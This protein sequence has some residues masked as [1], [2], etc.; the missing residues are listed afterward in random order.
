VGALMGEFYDVVARWKA[1]PAVW[2]DQ[3]QKGWRTY[4]AYLVQYIRREKL[5]GQVL[6]KNTGI[7]DAAG[8]GGRGQ[9]RWRHKPG[10]LKKTFGAQV[11]N[12]LE[13]QFFSTVYGRAWEFGF[14]RKQYDVVTTPGRMAGKPP[15]T[16]KARLMFYAGGHWRF[17]RKVTIP[18]Q[19]FPAKPHIRPSIKETFDRLHLLVLRP[20]EKYL[21]GGK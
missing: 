7:Y 14:D 12:N 13:A 16:S 4:I 18:A 19:R 6:G 20:L 17:A 8:A 21:T 11:Y 15:S 1:A 9:A 10:T 5:S 3:R 2:R